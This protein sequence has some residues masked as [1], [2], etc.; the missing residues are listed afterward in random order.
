MNKIQ[1]NKKIFKNSLL[2]LLGLLSLIKIILP[3]LRIT[4]Q[5]KYFPYFDPYTIKFVSENV[6]NKG[7]VPLN[8]DYLFNIYVKIIVNLLHLDY[9]LF[10]RW[11]NYLTILLT[12][13]VLFFF[14]KKIFKPKYFYQYISIFF[15]L[16][17]FFSYN[18]SIFRFGMTLREN[19]FI[20]LGLVLLIILISSENTKMSLFKIL[21]SSFLLAN[22]IGG[23]ILVAYIIIGTMFINFLIRILQ[24][25]PITNYIAIILI[26]FILSAYFIKMEIP[27]LMG[28]VKM[29]NNL[30][31]NLGG[32]INESYLSIR[33]FNLP[34]D[35]L[36]IPLGIIY[37]LKSI[38]KKTQKINYVFVSYILS[39][40]IL[41]LMSFITKFGIKQ[42][43]LLIY[44]YIISTF[45]IINTFINL[46]LTSQKNHKYLIIVVTMVFFCSI[47]SKNNMSFNITRPINS[48]N[49]DQLSEYIKN[50]N[51]K[52]D[53]NTYCGFSA[54]NL[55]NYIYPNSYQN[56]RVIDNNNYRFINPKTDT[57][58]LLKYD[59]YFLSRINESILPFLNKKCIIY[60]N[61]FIEY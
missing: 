13:L 51:I 40:S 47:I 38:F 24:K 10:I 53:S 60:N 30:I 5:D 20:P 41:Y 43:R 14:Y 7:F 3:F 56:I 9:Y 54:C 19:F 36:L 44:I 18:M 2:I 61:C 45:F 39:V 25:K 32:K 57:V 6:F 22:I 49:I 16:M 55:L 21:L 12:F 59:N 11:G 28:Q 37:Y 33:H 15:G 58:F 27:G 29:G 52:I 26:S 48:K 8:W 31:E 50:K 4:L 35:I 46:L 23:H 42:D 1:Y 34:F 17:Y